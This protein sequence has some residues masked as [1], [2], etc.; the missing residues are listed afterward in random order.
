M[1][2]C[3]L[4]PVFYRTQVAKFHNDKCSEFLHT[5]P[6]RSSEVYHPADLPR[7]NP[8]LPL[9]LLD[10]LSLGAQCLDTMSFNDA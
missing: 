4:R 2:A 8:I 6:H 5:S 10:R 9:G 1:P 7:V 3:G